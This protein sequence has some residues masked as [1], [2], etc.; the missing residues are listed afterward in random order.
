MSLPERAGG[1]SG[2][3]NGRLTGEDQVLTEE[4]MRALQKQNL[5]AALRQTNWRVSGKDGAAELL[6]IKPTT[7]TD[8]FKII[9]HSQA[10]S[11]ARQPRMDIQSKCQRRIQR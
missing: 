5:T 1:I 2:V 3:E 7:L 11:L 10:A 9:R 8:R 4:Q 6:G